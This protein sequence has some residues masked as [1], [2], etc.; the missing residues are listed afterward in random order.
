M[1][2][3]L[4]TILE[5][6]AAPGQRA[7]DTEWTLV[8][9]GRVLFRHK[10]LLFSIV[11]AGILVT[12]FASAVQTP[13]YRSHASLQ[14]QG[15]NDNFLSLRDIYPTSA[16]SADNVINVQTQAEILRQDALLD[17]ALARLRLDQRPGN[18]GPAGSGQ[19]AIDELRRNVQIAPARG[20]N[21]I[22][23]IC[24]AREPQLAADLANILAQTFI[25]EGIEARK[26]SA[27]QTQSLL[28]LER[29]TLGRKLA[30]LE[31]EVDRPGW[32]DRAS[33]SYSTLKRELDANRQ[34]YQSISQHIDEARVASAVDESNVRLVSAA[35]P[36]TYPY[37]PN[38]A[39][40]LTIGAVVG[41]LLAIGCIML[42]EQTNSVWSMP[43]EAS[44]SLAIPELGAIPRGDLRGFAGIR[45]KQGFDSVPVEQISLD[46]VSPGLS[47]SFRATT[48]SIL[49]AGNRGDHPR[50]LVVTSARSGEGKTTVASNLAIALTEIG[51]KVLLIDGDLRRPRLHQI[52][53]QPN[54]WGLSD[55]LREKNAVEDLPL[56]TLVKRTTVPRLSLLPGGTSA[57]NVFALLLSGRMARLVPRFRQAFDYVLIDAPPCLEYA[58]ARILGGFAEKLI[59]VVRADYT[60]RQTAQAAV[61]RLLLDRIPIMG[62]IFNGWDPSHHNGYG[63]SRPRCELV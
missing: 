39:L 38:L 45:L 60:G 15:R 48:A 50:L 6:R 47:E 43:G 36:A 5:R 53:N 44:A 27:R 37:K 33:P 62:V 40:N 28:S 26:R 34:F 55:L 21:I 32:R 29:E 22:R 14:I 58:D 49:S 42:R 20:S 13:M 63:Y 7:V 30:E 8:E 57:E 59:L 4:N 61:Q 3:K 12:L 24:A 10:L 41:L 18:A 19:A 25:D 9:C 23:I 2:I 54:S 16:S 46:Q 51:A 17:K 35:Q 11:A 52:F 31:D 1:P 56:E